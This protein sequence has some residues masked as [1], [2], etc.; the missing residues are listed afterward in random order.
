VEGGVTLLIAA[1]RTISFL[2]S[3]FE[4]KASHR[5][6]IWMDASMDHGQDM[7]KR[8]GWIDCYYYDSASSRPLDGLTSGGMIS[9]ERRCLLVVDAWMVLGALDLEL[10][11]LRNLLHVQDIWI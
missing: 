8:M 2:Q 7:G 10:F 9:G 4:K 5:W 1:T 3:T 6:W 11:E